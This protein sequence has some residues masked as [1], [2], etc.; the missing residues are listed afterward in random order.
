MQLCQHLGDGV[1]L[2]HLRPDAVAQVLRVER[3]VDLSRRRLD[4]GPSAG[5]ISQITR[6]IGRKLLPGPGVSPGTPARDGDSSR[7]AARG[8]IRHLQRA[9]DLATRPMRRHG[10]TRGYGAELVM[11]AMKQSDEHGSAN[12]AP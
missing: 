6:T 5:L 10:E 11:L 9:S 2:P 1:L 12:S 7:D 8:M 4:R 3:R